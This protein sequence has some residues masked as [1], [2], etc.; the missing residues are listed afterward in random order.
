[1]VGT[2]SVYSGWIPSLAW[3]EYGLT[4]YPAS[5]NEIPFFLYENIIKAI[6]SRHEDMDFFVV[7][8]RGIRKMRGPIKEAI[9]RRVTDVLPW[10]ENRMDALE[11]SFEVL[12]TYNERPLTAMEKASYY[13]PLLKYHSRWSSLEAADYVTMRDKYK[14]TPPNDR[15]NLEFQTS[16]IQIDP[17][18]LTKRCGELDALQEKAV[19]SLLDYAREENLRLLFVSFPA[20]NNRRVQKLFN[21]VL[22]IAESRGYDTLNF[23]T[24]KAYQE[25]GLNFSED[26]R[27]DSHLNSK[28]AQK[29][30]K[31]LGE[32]IRS[33]YE[34]PDHRGEEAYKSWDDAW[35]A[36]EEM[37][38]AGWEKAEAAQ[39][40]NG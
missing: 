27:N 1:M 21:E 33:S 8:I 7:D 23:N 2:S 19:Y 35:T 3:K 32:Y 18:N 24:E 5:F 30:T 25:V 28:G 6:R 31:Y 29:V 39:A 34:L 40:A 37:Y 13:F 12:E 38:R 9:V 22:R 36:Y 16:E 11:R 10:S 26:F 15:Q 14:G 17:K 20:N 4:I